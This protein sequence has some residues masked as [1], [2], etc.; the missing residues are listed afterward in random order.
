[1]VLYLILYNFIPTSLPIDTYAPETAAVNHVPIGKMP[2][3]TTKNSATTLII[4]HAH[5]S[6]TISPFLKNI[7][8]KN[9]IILNLNLTFV[10]ISEICA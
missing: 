3:T 1:M 9:E 6:I 4:T 2:V 5:H 10:K 8:F 7:V